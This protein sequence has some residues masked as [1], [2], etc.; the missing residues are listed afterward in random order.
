[1]DDKTRM[2]LV[3]GDVVCDHNYYRGNRPTADSTQPMGVRFACTGGGA[4]LLKDIINETAKDLP[5]WSTAFGL[6]PDYE[7]LPP[8]Y[9]AYRVWEP[10]IANPDENDPKKQFSVWRAGEPPL[11]YGHPALAPADRAAAAPK[12]EAA[13]T[14]R[15]PV[16]A[17]AILVIDDAGLGFRHGGYKNHWPFAANG[18]RAHAPRWVVLQV[19]GSAGEGDLWNDSVERF[20][21][22]LVLI[23][24]AENLRRRDIRIGRGLSWETTAED[25]S[26]ELHGN[27]LMKPLL[28]ARH[29]IVTF[30]SDGACWLDNRAASNR[31]MLV[32]DA[33]RAEGE[34]AERHAK[35]GAFEFLS[36]FTAA[37]VCELCRAEQ[38]P[39]PNHGPDFETALAAGLGASREVRRLGHGPIQVTAKQPNGS[40]KDVINP[41]PG[42]P[43]AAIGASIRRPA[44]EF[45]SAPI[46]SV[47]AKRGDWMML[48]EWHVHARSGARQRPHLEAALAVAILG[49]R[50]LERFPVAKFGGLQTVDRKEIESLRTIRELIHTYE[51]AG[52]QKKP[53]SLGVFGPPGAGKSFGVTQ[54]AK[55]VL[56][57]DDE[58]ILTFNLSQFSDPA[59]L[60]GAFHR[61]RDKVLAGR[62]PVVFWDEFDSQDYKWLQ[63][64][65]AP[66][67][68]GA[69]Q[70]GQIIHPIGKCI[71]VFAGATSP[72]FE[73][74]GPR[75][76]DD[77][78]V[79]ER[80][81]LPD[82]PA[83]LGHIE[84]QWLDFVLK[85]GPDFKSRLV[86]Y[87]N[88][89]GP[90]PRRIWTKE[91]GR[92]RWEDD[93]TDVCYPIRRAL[94]IRAQFKL[95]DDERLRLDA[96]VVQ[97]LLEVPRYKSGARS[98]EFLCQHLRGQALGTP[99]RSGLPGGQLLD[100]H[101]DSPVFWEICERD[102]DFV[103]VAGDL[104]RGLHED[105]VRNL[106]KN[107]RE[108]NPNAVPW[109]ALDP[110]RRAANV[111]QAVRIPRIVGLAQLRVVKGP[112]LPSVEEAR[113]RRRLRDTAAVLAEA[114]HN[115]WMVER[116][117]SGWRYAR[118]RD[119]TR[120]L[121]PLLIPYAQLPS[122]QQAKDHR[123]VRGQRGTANVPAV[124]DYIARV[125]RI[126]FRIEPMP[127]T[128]PTRRRGPRR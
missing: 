7:A 103:S 81:G 49:P 70:D 79:A 98:L 86:G 118:Q 71:F 105:W 58:D 110:D 128:A 108:T 3:T 83:H 45:V 85:K 53:L 82:A 21:D 9:H 26:S 101:V 124:P 84:Q 66:M 36:C 27:P 92:R 43:F 60:H 41:A 48:D 121:H 95:K 37:I 116:M 68:D 111:A 10:Q 25:V 30:G 75:N 47:V 55:A 44:D 127:G 39:K 115:Y 31:S 51:K 50:A 69:F 8:T 54:I 29:L 94:F 22:R 40:E 74:F 32:F 102:R 6:D 57:I 78:S 106:A 90:N 97:S 16:G 12:A 76:P 14:T 13:P 62:T 46:P 15:L 96:G 5:G 114:E 1:M 77:V 122:V 125:K 93:P 64:L 126:G 123:V 89:L 73:A 34:W 11:G 33:A 63:Y 100:M 2:I 18:R 42:F 113:V 72:S 107:E 104:A 88:V 17:N 23:V 99:T 56:R 4:L 19:T 87:L 67:Q 61:V 28:A 65:L 91:A 80:S 35:G 117:L 59:A 52:A 119:D 112:P 109:E 24:S 20:G 120:K 38:D